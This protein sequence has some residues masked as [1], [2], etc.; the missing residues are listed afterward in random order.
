MICLILLG[1]PSILG[2]P[3]VKICW[4]HY[5]S[6]VIPFP[7]AVLRLMRKMTTMK[8]YDS[9]HRNVVLHSEFAIPYLPACLDAHSPITGIMNFS[10]L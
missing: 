10:L 5:T 1:F 4:M 2:L 7:V 6:D 3:Y 8:N 9:N